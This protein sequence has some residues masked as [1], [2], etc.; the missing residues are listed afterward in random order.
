[1]NTD[2]KK[3]IFYF[4]LISFLFKPL[5]LFEYN[6]IEDSGD[7]IAY[8]IHSATLAFDFDIDYK[9]DFKSEKV[10]VNNETNSP[11]H[12]PGSGYLASPFVFLFSTFDNLI[13]KEIDRLNPVGTFSYLGYFF[14]TLIYM[15]CTLLCIFYIFSYI[16]L[17]GGRFKS[18]NLQ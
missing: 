11:I 17:T 16:C 13:D 4:F 14:S 1:M 6:S 10:L 2:T 12:Y 8:W 7:D 3:I 9:D 18:L 5:W 15:F